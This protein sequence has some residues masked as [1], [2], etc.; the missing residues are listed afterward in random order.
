MP[1]HAW[2]KAKKKAKTS[3]SSAV[4][5]PEFFSYQALLT[6]SAVP[7]RL[8]SYCNRILRLARLGRKEEVLRMFLALFDDKAMVVCC[9][10]VRVDTLIELFDV[11]FIQMC[12]GGA[13]EEE[14]RRKW[15]SVARSCFVKTYPTGSRQPPNPKDPTAKT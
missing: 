8:Q 14:E 6:R 2:R 7:S 11:L 12:C 1:A 10:G 4:L 13:G 3:E 9:H 15:R 5:N